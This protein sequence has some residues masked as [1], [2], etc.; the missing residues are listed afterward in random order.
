MSATTIYA[1]ATDGAGRP[2]PALFSGPGSLD[3]AERWAAILAQHREALEARGREYRDARRRAH[4]RRM[5]GKD[6]GEA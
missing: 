2:L 3:L 1:D 5:A 4:W 6:E